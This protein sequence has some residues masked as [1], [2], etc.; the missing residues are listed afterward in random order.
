LTPFDPQNTTNSDAVFIILFQR[1]NSQW[2]GI[3]ALS[4]RLIG[5]SWRI[6]RFGTGLREGLVGSGRWPA[7]NHQEDIEDEERDGEIVEDGCLMGVWP[8]LTAL[9]TNDR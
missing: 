2:Q 3:S 4:S 8:R 6:V 5:T 9:L 1:R 7:N